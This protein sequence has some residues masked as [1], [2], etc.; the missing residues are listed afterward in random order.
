MRCTQETRLHYTK[1]Y[2][3]IQELRTVEISVRDMLNKLSLVGGTKT[4][5]MQLFKGVYHEYVLLKINRNTVNSKHH[6][7]QLCCIKLV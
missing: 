4:Q 3:N 5:R 2:F 7:I 1:N 6:N